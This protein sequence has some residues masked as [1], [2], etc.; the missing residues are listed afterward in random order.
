[1]VNV[2]S[3]IFSLL[4]RNRTR[5]SDETGLWGSRVVGAS[6]GGGKSARDKVKVRSIF[7]CCLNGTGRGFR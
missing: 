6:K 5:V 2:W 3:I 1:M 7:C 4:E